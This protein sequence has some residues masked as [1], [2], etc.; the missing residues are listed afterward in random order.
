[1][2]IR[3]KTHKAA[4]TGKEY[5]SY[6]LI[7][8]VRT[9]RGPRQRILLDL[10]C[11][12]T[13]TDA[14]CKLVANRIEEI[15]TGVQPLIPYP[16]H[17]ECL[18]STYARKL[19]R[20]KADLAADEKHP[21]QTNQ[22]EQKY[23]S[24]NLDSLEHDHCR[25]IGIE[26]IAYETFKK[27]K[28]NEL[29]SDIGL[30]SRQ[31]EIATGAIIGRLAYPSSE[32]GTHHWLKNRSG[33]DELM[34]T[35]FSRLSLNALYKAGDNLIKHKQLI[36]AHLEATEKE[37]F[38]LQDTIVLYDLTNT[39]FEGRAK[40][41]SLAHRGHSKEKR[42]D[43]PLVTLGLV[44]GESGF[45]IR[46]RILPG[47]ISE[48]S[49][50]KAVL[51]QLESK[52]NQRSVVVLDGGIATEDNLEYLRNNGYSYIVASRSKSCEVPP[53]IAM[54]VV[55]EKKDNVIRAALVNETHDN[56]TY[57]YCHSTAREA[58]EASMRSLL[59]ER[60]ELDLKKVASSLKKKGGTKSYSKVLQ[61]IGRLKEKHKK[62]AHYYAIDV[63]ADANHLQAE[64]I[65]WKFDKK[66]LDDRF[67]GTYLLRVY[68][69][70]WEADRLWNTY[71]TL[72]EVE[73]GFR[74]LKTD[75]GLRPVFHKIDRRVEGHLFITVL[76]YHIMQTIMYQ[77][78]LAGM[79]V[80]W[81]TL[82]RIMSS[83]VRVTTSM[84]LQDGRQVHI[85]SSTNAE[86]E[87]KEIHQALG[88]SNRPGKIVKTFV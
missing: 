79:N 3:K 1:M 85:R 47:N 30:N 45:P 61:R 53:G 76:A 10:G 13:I 14:D 69:L 20:K 31:I 18:A 86:P 44:L 12:L 66:R 19:I 28:L 27:L 87:Q 41:I 39:Y 40:D 4:K 71:V 15:I 7:E 57:L 82:R 75:L 78:R 8:S 65:T 62:V 35:D 24:V 74:C 43:A 5:H 77:L 72:T 54:E 21:W 23:Y 51:E 88:F 16:E 81:M 67:Q 73:E 34:D 63:K 2:F 42:Y 68:G 17:I 52:S 25:T 60:F 80:R 9:E 70:D 58:K 11:H 46:S 50:L 56:E 64:S 55:K 22:E 48:P 38:S 26:H 6:Q 29:L 49:T 83:Q 59:Q 36:E 32:R 33:L 84:R 37:L